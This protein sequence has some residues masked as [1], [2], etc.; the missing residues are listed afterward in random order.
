MAYKKNYE[1]NMAAY[2]KCNEDVL[3]EANSQTELATCI[4]K[5]QFTFCEFI[6]RR[7]KL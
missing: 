2:K 1:N 5:A 6:M 7:R 4:R 3:T